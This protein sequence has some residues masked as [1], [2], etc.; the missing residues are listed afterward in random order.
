MCV[1]LVFFL[2]IYFEI[3]IQIVWQI[4]C[5]SIHKIDHFFA[6]KNMKK[7]NHLLLKFLYTEIYPLNLIEKIIA[8]GVFFGITYVIVDQMEFDPN[9]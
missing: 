7:S 2:L 4:W 5:Q 9:H 8:D 6:T 3:H 1:F